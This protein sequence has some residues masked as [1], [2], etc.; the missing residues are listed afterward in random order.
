MGVVVNETPQPL[1]PRGTDLVRIAQ[2][3]GWAAG[4]VWN[5]AENLAPQPGFFFCET[6]SLFA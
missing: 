1:Y 4:P 2:K 5:G 3:V 6:A